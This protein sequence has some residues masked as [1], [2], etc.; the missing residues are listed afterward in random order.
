MILL[1]FSWQTAV[2]LTCHL[3]Y[4]Y[5]AIYKRYLVLAERLFHTEDTL[6]GKEFFA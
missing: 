5:F 1:F 4:Y 2:L 3:L 6:T